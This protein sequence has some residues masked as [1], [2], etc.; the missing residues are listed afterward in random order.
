MPLTSLS[1]RTKLSRNCSLGRRVGGIQMRG[2]KEEEWKK[3]CAQAA[4]EQDP[5]KLYA[6]VTEINRLLHEKEDRLRR[7]KSAEIDREPAD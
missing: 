3:F 4:I 6:L 1:A 5:E 7:R 2:E